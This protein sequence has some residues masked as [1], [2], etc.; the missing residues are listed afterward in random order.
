MS[1][2]RSESPGC[3]FRDVGGQKSVP[4]FLPPALRVRTEGRDTDWA[5]RGTGIHPNELRGPWP[6]PTTR[7]T[8]QVDSCP[9]ELHRKADG[10]RGKERAAHLMFL[11]GI[12]KTVC[13][14][15][16]VIGADPLR[17]HFWRRCK[18]LLG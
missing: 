10:G 17:L 1:L 8:Q 5:R 2:L 16:F 6:R 14:A 11:R 15:D 7:P 12:W 3:G 4:S 18:Q 9:Q 13:V